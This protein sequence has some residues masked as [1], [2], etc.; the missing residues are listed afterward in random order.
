MNLQTVCLKDHHYESFLLL[1][2]SLFCANHSLDLC[3]LFRF[4]IF[5]PPDT[6]CPILGLFMHF[7]YT[8]F[9]MCILPCGIFLLSLMM[10][11]IGESSEFNFNF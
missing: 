11:L 6:F 5:V 8:N 10:P 3:V 4:Y 2:D 1:R 9:F 7:A